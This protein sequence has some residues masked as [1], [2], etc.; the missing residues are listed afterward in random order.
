M[1]A[2]S[3]PPEG[4]GEPRLSWRDRELLSA[5]RRLAN[6]RAQV[7]SLE[8]DLEKHRSVA[9]VDPADVRQVE[10]LESELTKLQAKASARFGGGAARERIPEV[11]MQQRLLLERLGYESY[12]AFQARARGAD[13]STAAVDT[14]YVDFARRELAAAE[15]AYEQLLA[16]PDEEDDALPPSRRPHAAS[17]PDG[18]ERPSTIDLTRGESS[19]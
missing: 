11:E 3:T 6:S 15:E 19:A 14:G 9:P 13:A 18:R 1:S 5:L 17:T 12:A 8:A 7:Q 10:A 2:D 4:D 16:M